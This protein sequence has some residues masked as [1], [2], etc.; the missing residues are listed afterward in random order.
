MLVRDLIAALSTLDPDLPVAVCRPAS[1]CCGECFLPLDD[2]DTAPSVFVHAPYG[3]GA[4]G[5][6]TMAVL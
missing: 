1:C 6:V 2:Y 3:H 4:D 5:T